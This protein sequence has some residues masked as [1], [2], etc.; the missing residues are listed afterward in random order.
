MT[1]RFHLPA[2][3]ALALVLPVAAH[4]QSSERSSG[5][6]SAFT[7]PVADLN[8]AYDRN[9]DAGSLAYGSTYGGRN[10]YIR[11][12][13]RSYRRSAYTMPVVSQI[14]AGFFDPNGSPSSGFMFGFRG[15]PMV[16]PHVQVG[17]SA[18]W[19]HKSSSAEQQF[20]VGDV[21]GGVGG[22]T[23]TTTSEGTTTNFVPLLGFIQV[24]G[25]DNMSVIPYAGI[26]GGYEILTLENS[27]VEIDGTSIDGTYGG[28]GWQLWA[29]AGVPL[30][31]Q[32]RL[33]GE[34]F[35]NTAEVAQDL[36]GFQ[37]PFRV[38]ID[39]NGFGARFGVSWGF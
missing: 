30:S 34:G 8:A 11:Y 4:A 36:D 23:T 28:W 20:D 1:S 13:P 39:R 26:G 21:G 38:K 19:E 22:V 15:G 27:G 9:E 37:G 12:R 29:G 5:S 33:F 31:G 18:D 10:D 35:Y 25:D 16:D 17:I 6:A 24:G 3:L 2:V 14:H 32:A 7:L